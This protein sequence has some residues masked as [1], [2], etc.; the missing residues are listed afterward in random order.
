[1]RSIWSRGI[2]SS[3]VEPADDEP[4]RS[5]SINTSVWPRLAPRSNAP[6]TEPGPPFCTIS[7]PGCR[8]SSSARL[9]TPLRRISSAPRRVVAYSLG[10]FV[11]SASSGPSAQTGLLRLQLSS[12]GVE[13]L[14]VADASIMPDIVS[15]NTNTTAILIGEKATELVRGAPR[16]PVSPGNVQVGA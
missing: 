11:W 3:V 10:N 7:K 5:P 4:T 2:A 6:D 12:R 15:A 8:C 9:C 13:G 14:R 16:T 1:M